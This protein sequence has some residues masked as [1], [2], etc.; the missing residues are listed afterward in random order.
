MSVTVDNGEAFITAS[1]DSPTI[2]VE[3]QVGMTVVA[4]P[5]PSSVV[6]V[7]SA[8]VVRIGEFPTI[9]PSGGGDSPPEDLSLVYVSG[10]LTT[11]TRESGEEKT[12]VY[13]GQGRLSTV[14]DSET[15]ITKTLAYD[16]SSGVLSTVT[17]SP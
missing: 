14:T 8:Q 10:K 9:A 7:P 17:I 5:A 6:V 1:T 11:V 15:A 13:D 12:L 3:D 2:I 4:G 16:P